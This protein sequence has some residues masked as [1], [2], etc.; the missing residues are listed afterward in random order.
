MIIF[1]FQPTS[2]AAGQ[3]DQPDTVIVTIEG[4][5]MLIQVWDDGADC[6]VYV[7]GGAVITEGPDC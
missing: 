4:G 3:T 6:N 7:I 5:Q 1:S 2:P